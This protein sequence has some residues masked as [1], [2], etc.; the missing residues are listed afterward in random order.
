MHVYVGCGLTQ[1]P[2]QFKQDVESFKKKLAQLPGI[3]VLEF[4]GLVN[5]TSRDVY[6]TDLGNVE[7]CD[8]F[9][10]I[11]DYPAIGLGMEIQ[12]GR[13]H[14]KPTLCLHHED[15]KVTRMLQ[16][17]QEV[18]YLTLRTYHALS[19]DGLRIAQEYLA[20]RMQVAVT[21]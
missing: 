13:F 7:R 18:G 20:H 9:I 1:A 3:E 8:V 2:D 19:D 21:D 5:G 16:G 15:A 17:A 11:A 14:E 6:K 4:I 12:H 10:A